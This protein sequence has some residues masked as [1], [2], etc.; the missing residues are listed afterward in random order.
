M[1]VLT[2]DVIN[3]FLDV[4][5]SLRENSSK[6]LDASDEHAVD[7]VSTYLVNVGKARPFHPG[8]SAYLRP[9]QSEKSAGTRS[10]RALQHCRMPGPG[11]SSPA[12]R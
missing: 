1:V 11:V 10:G 8:S 3:T 2:A 7:T 6:R 5:R 12:Q 4:L 9:L